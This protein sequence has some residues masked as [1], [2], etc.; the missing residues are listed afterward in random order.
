M[1]TERLPA[2][3]GAE[4]VNQRRVEDIRVT[5]AGHLVGEPDRQVGTVTDQSCGKRRTGPG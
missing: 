2:E 1:R 4:F 3:A 5:D